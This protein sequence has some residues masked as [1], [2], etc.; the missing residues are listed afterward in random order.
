LCL[1]GSG[2]KSSKINFEPPTKSSED[3]GA[4]ER[5]VISKSKSIDVWNVQCGDV[6]RAELLDDCRIFESMCYFRMYEK[7]VITEAC[8]RGGEATPPRFTS[9]SASM[10]SKFFSKSFSEGGH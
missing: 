9:L 5:L 3:L 4:H 2:R 6:W 10:D 1:S 8:V 7:Y